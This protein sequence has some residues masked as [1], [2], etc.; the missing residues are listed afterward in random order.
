MDS[1]QVRG[2][3]TQIECFSLGC[4]FP[5]A[6]VVISRGFFYFSFVLFFWRS[7]SI[8]QSFIVRSYRPLVCHLAWYL[9]F[10][11]LLPQLFD[12]LGVKMIQNT[13]QGS[14]PHKCGQ[15][16][17]CNAFNAVAA[18]FAQDISAFLSLPRALTICLHLWNFLEAGLRGS[19]GPS[20]RHM[21]DPRRVSL[22][23]QYPWTLT[24]S[25]ISY[26]GS[27]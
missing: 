9:S 27:L 11:L 25:T 14:S 4:I 20:H 15:E 16:S 19:R 5:D 21:P 26:K 23:D 22:S 13:V 12:F 2:V 18:A 7:Y 1:S 10:P 24:R 17:C 6:T 8:I 3:C